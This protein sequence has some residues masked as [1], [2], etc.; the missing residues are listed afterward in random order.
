MNNVVQEIAILTDL[1]QSVHRRFYKAIGNLHR[2]YQNTFSI[3]SASLLVKI[4]QLLHP[5]HVIIQ[6]S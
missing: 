2:C 1:F 5:H 6:T 3:A 4:E